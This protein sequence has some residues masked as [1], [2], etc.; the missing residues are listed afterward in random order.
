M[1]KTRSVRLKAEVDDSGHVVGYASTWTR[2]PD[3]YGDVVARGAFADCIERIKADGTTLP[4]LYNH[5]QWDIDNFI[6]TVTSLE[7][8]EHGLRFEAD[9][10]DTPRAQ[11]ARELVKDGRLCKVSFAYD[12]LDMGSVTLDDGRTA[13]ELRKLDIFE[14]SLVFVP[15]NPDTSIVEAKGLSARDLSTVTKAISDAARRGMEL[16]AKAGRR[17]SKADEESLRD[18]LGHA[19]ALEEILR[20]LIEEEGSGDGGDGDGSGANGAGGSAKGGEGAGAPKGR[21]AGTDDLEAYRA[22]LVSAYG[23]DCE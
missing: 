10:D 20:S 17:N 22:A 1:R 7:E 13:N 16:G 2:E 11:R 14:V 9:F 21:E 8:D 19:E 6:G 18:A 12:V 4:L 3:S 15:A 5:D 23:N